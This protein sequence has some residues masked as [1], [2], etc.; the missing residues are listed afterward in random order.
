MSI[1]S[2]ELVWISVSDLRKAIKFYTETLGFKLLS[3][4]EKF[5]WAELQGKEGGCLLGIAQSS[6]ELSGGSNAVTTMTVEN[7]LASKKELVKKGVKTLGEIMEVPGQVK[8]QLCEDS[9]GNK[10]QLVEKI[11]A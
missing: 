9:D 8:L 5:G 3:Y 10:F 2:I 7:L 11:E 4:E 6:E 1:K